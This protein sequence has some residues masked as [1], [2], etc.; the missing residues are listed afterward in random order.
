MKILYIS[1]QKEDSGYGRSCRDYLEALKTTGADIASVPIVL[2]KPGNFNERTENNVLTNCDY[3]VQ[4]VLPH[5]MS[6]SG[7]FQKNVGICL[8]ETTDTKLTYWQAHL[9]MMD[10]VWYPY[11]KQNGYTIPHPVN[12]DIYSQKFPKMN[13]LEANGTFK[14]Y[15]IGEVSKRKNLSALLM[16][17]LQAFQPSDPVSLTLKV[18]KSGYSAEQVKQEIEDLIEKTAR[19]LRLYPLEAYPRIFVISDYWADEQI[20]ALHKMGDC[21]VSSSYGEALCYPMI[22]ALGF[23]KPVIS[24]ANFSDFYKRYGYINVVPTEKESCYGHLEAFDGHFTAWEQWNSVKIKDLIAALRQEYNTRHTP[25]ND[26]SG[27]SY[28]KVGK[29]M[30]ERLI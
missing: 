27:L 6:Y 29:L 11:L 1:H 14:F 18:N 10:E 21:F 2:G 8:N 30:L 26:L 19:G 5:H 9:D 20:Y 17:Y 23:N 25:D 7:K 24:T 4:H 16:A 3:V 15:W 12:T 28:S 22:D 13:I